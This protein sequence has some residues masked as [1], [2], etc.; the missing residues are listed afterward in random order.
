MDYTPST[1]LQRT[2]MAIKLDQLTTAEIGMRKQ[3]SNAEMIKV[4]AAIKLAEGKD[5]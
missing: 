1:P 2:D 4:V 3:V 5:V